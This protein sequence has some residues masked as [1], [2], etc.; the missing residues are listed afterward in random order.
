MPAGEPTDLVAG[1]EPDR[2]LRKALAPSGRPPQPGRHPAGALHRERRRHERQAAPLHGV[3]RQV[4]R[5][6]E[7]DRLAAGVDQLLVLR[8][9]DILRFAPG[10]KPQRIARGIDDFSFVTN[11]TGTRIAAGAGSPRACTCSGPVTI[12]DARSG[13]VV[14]T[15]AGEARQRRS[16]PLARRIE[17]RFRARRVRRIRE[18]VRHLDGEVGREP[19]PAAGEVGGIRCGR[20]KSGR[21]P[22]S[23]SAGTSVCA[24]CGSAGGGRSQ[25]L[26]P[27]R[28]ENV[29][30]W[31]PDGTSIAV[32]RGS[33]NLR[34]AGRRR[35]RDG[36][37]TQLCSSSRT[38]RRP[39]GRRTRPSSSPT[40]LPKR[41]S[42]GRPR[43][44]RSTARGRSLVSSCR[45]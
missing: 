13:A 44:S 30:G 8:D 1:R 38:R 12:L 19:P 20:R 37:G 23:R 31:S 36:E 3:H 2:V 35:R 26:V 29:F 17:G 10:S 32:Q 42:A 6:A 15:A 40:R 34:Q 9:G 25:A 33:G 14:G 18:A 11:P 24:A 27:R 41:Q 39:S 45:S 21:S 4:P 28:V 22:T 16:E 43:A 5:P 7:P